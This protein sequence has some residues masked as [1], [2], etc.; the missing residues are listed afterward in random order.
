MRRSARTR[1]LRIGPTTRRS[2]KALRRFFCSTKY[3]NSLIAR[4][5]NTI[6]AHYHADEIAKLIK[7]NVTD[8]DLLESTAASVGGLARM[9][10]PLVRG[11]LNILNG[12]D[13][14]AVEDHTR[15]VKEALTISGHL[16]NVV[17]NLF[18][19]LMRTHMGAV[20]EKHE[21]IVEV[22]PLVIRAGEAAD[23]LKK[24]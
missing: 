6:G 11:I 16:I 21:T 9:A 10:D 3:K 20:V 5:R 13:F 22:P 24:D 23:V 7:D 2:L 14:M 18:D 15:Q 1:C 4:V 8:E 19:A 12:G 17:D